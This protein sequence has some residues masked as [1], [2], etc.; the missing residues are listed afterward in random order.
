MEHKRTWIGWLSLAVM[1]AVTGSVL[2]FSTLSSAEKHTDPVLQP[3]NETLRMLFSASS[4]TVFEPLSSDGGFI[5]QARHQNR[6]TGY[7]AQ[8]TVQG[9]GGPFEVIAAFSPDGVIQGVYVG[10]S[11]FRETEGLGAKVKEED[12][13]KQFRGQHL[14]VTL[15]Q[16]IDAVAGATVSSQAVVDGVNA[17]ADRLRALPD[18][19]FSVA[20]PSQKSTSE[21]TG[22]ASVLGYNGPVLVRLTLDDSGTIAQLDVGGARFMETE[23]VGSRVLDESFI[24]QFNGLTPPLSLN[25]DIDAIS[26]AT[27]SSQAVVDAVNEAA[28]FLTQKNEPSDTK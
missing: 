11:S 18:V 20:D 12:F 14:P 4:E 23:G 24:S 1:L 8:R 3:Y 27:V 13:L 21:R 9:Y 16:S 6:I 22:N 2:L 5:C 10:G 19:Q 7:A 17:A 26:G 15:G 28:A 25:E